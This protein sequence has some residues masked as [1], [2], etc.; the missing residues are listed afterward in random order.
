[1]V[2]CDSCCTRGCP[3][4]P[5][6]TPSK[7]PRQ[8]AHG[9]V[10]SKP[11]APLPPSQTGA[12]AELRTAAGGAICTRWSQHTQGHTPQ[13]AAFK[14]TGPTGAWRQSSKWG[15]G[16]W[17]A[18][19]P[20]HLGP[21]CASRCCCCTPTPTRTWSMYTDSITTPEY[22]TTHRRR[23]SPRHSSSKDIGAHGRAAGAKA[24]T[25]YS[26]RVRHAGACCG[27]GAAEQGR[28]ARV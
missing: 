2:P 12:A 1:M 11:G 17:L 22:H 7:A 27:E 20:Q 6:S 23:H 8:H 25:S 9:P 5:L 4:G 13:P 28:Q 18:G 16:G 10:M 14:Q 21:P 19:V 26:Q 15:A 3:A 24:D